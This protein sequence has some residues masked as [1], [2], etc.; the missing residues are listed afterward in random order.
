MTAE[1]PPYRI[2]L[3]DEVRATPWN[4]RHVVS[5]FAG[6]GGSSTGYRMDGYRV[7]AACE[8]VPAAQDSYAANMA[9][10]TLLYRQD[11]RTLTGE[12]IMRD[13][14]LAKGDLDV[15][16]GSPPCEPFSTSGKLNE[17]WGRVVDYSG[18]TQ[19]TDDLF[20]EY[21]RLVD[22]LRPRVF[23]AE[24]VTGLV[25][26][27]SKGYFKL[28]LRTLRGLGYRVEARVL[29]ASYLGVPQARQRVIFVGVRGDLDQAPAHPDPLPYR[30]TIRDACPWISRVRY[31]ATVGRGARGGTS[32]FGSSARD[33]DVDQEPVGTLTANQSNL[34]YWR[35]TD[36]HAIVGG[37]A[38][39]DRFSVDEPAPT[40]QAAGLA[41]SGREQLLV[42][43]PEPTDDDLRGTNL[44]PAI[45]KAWGETRV[46]Q[47]HHRHFNLVRADPDAPSPTI[48]AIG[49]A[50]AGV[51]HPFEPRRFTIAEVKRLSGFP[52]D[53]TL[54]G[55]FQ[56]QW[57]RL[58]DCVPPP[59]MRHVA[60]TVRTRIL[61]QVET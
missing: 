40:F 2:P 34:T 49:G 46:G 29:D 27:V 42:T 58:G 59:M 22:Q 48:T 37:W 33:Y 60:H 17:R 39:G 13:T 41:G 11:M 6:C 4:G 38:L 12:Q 21:A 50:A 10:T 28:I 55:S 35:A 19:R 43:W 20:L 47:S 9:P 30:Y 1:K 8:F 51:S 3:M 25:R 15:L 54:T 14:G 5:I 31:D 53:Y 16:D 44:G 18:E 24:N 36:D 56:Q 61:E 7:L 52:D 26:G 45:R 32:E 57:E 23:V